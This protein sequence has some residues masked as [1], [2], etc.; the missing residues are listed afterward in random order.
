MTVTHDRET[1]SFPV[2]L[3]EDN[4]GDARLVA[5]FFRDEVLGEIPA[6]GLDLLR[7][8][9]PLDRLDGPLCDAVLGRRGSGR[10]L[11]ELSR[12]G[13]FL[14]ALDRAEEHFR[15]GLAWSEQERWPVQ[16]M[17]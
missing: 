9:A 14:T 2:L 10:L 17:Y 12:S 15:T 3:V 7:G 16:A 11:R 6:D 1:Q 13:V 4:P 8:T 5:D